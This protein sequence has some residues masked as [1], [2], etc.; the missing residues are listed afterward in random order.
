MRVF[1]AAGSGTALVVADANS[2]GIL[3]LLEDRQYLVLVS[4]VSDIR[5]TMLR[6]TASAIKDSKRSLGA[7][8]YY[9][10]VMNGPLSHGQSAVI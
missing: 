3:R 5:Q 1:F 6:L 8:R 9:N 10:L 2:I 7:A 4:K